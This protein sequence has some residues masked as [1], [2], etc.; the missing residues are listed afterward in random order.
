MK[1][2][3]PVRLIMEATVKVEMTSGGSIWLNGECIAKTTVA[4]ENTREK[5]RVLIKMKK[6]MYFNK[7]IE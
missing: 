7:F 4:D 5:R 2:I 6:G 3:S 1:L